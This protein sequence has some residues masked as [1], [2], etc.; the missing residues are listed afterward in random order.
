MA[1]GDYQIRHMKNATLLASGLCTALFAAAPA[2]ASSSDWHQTEGGRFRLVT[3]GQP[4]AEGKLQGALDIELKPGWKTYWR[5][6]G[7]AG[8]PPQVDVTASQNISAAEVAYPAPERHDDGYS[9]W[10]GYDYSVDLPV[11][12]TLAS[13]GAA[14][15]I[16]ADVFMGVCETICVPV[17]ARIELDPNIDPANAEDASLVKAAFAAL[18]QT[19]TPDFGATSETADGDMLTVTANLP[20]GMQAADLFI[21]GVDGYMFGAPALK[22]DNGQST[23]SVKVLERPKSPPAGKGIPYTLT[24]KGGAVDGFLPYP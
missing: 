6:P 12:L 10:A 8:V 13:S 18:P 24:T 3:S 22:A 1:A 19:A 21:A 11:T 23:F 2:H 7:D 15:K 20:K 5:D 16:V 9:K 17:Q 14:T 4:D